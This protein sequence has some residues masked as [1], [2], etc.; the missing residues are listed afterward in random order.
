MN[1]NFRL[2]NPNYKINIKWNNKKFNYMKIK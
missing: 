1:N 2:K